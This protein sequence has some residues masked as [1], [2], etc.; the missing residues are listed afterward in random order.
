M[1]F[2]CLPVGVNHFSLDERCNLIC[3]IMKLFM[4]F[5]GQFPDLSLL[6]P[7]QNESD[8]EIKLQ[9]SLHSK[10]VKLLQSIQEVESNLLS[11]KSES[12]FYFLIM[13]GGVP[14][15]PKRA[16]LIDIND[17]YPK[18]IN[19][20]KTDIV[21]F[22]EFFESLVQVPFFDN[23]FKCST[24]TRTYIYICTSKDF[25]SSWFLPRLQFRLPR[26]CPVH[27]LKIVPDYIDS[28]NPKELHKI[29]YESPSELRWFA[30]PTVFFGVKPK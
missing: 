12:I 9:D 23:V 26:T 17:F 3:R 7:P 16:F 18:T 30:S 11:S 2:C 28:H 21:S 6:N 29:L 25:S 24:P 27:V 20:N 1:D 14:S 10:E 19:V 15:S 22:R 5:T 4:Y 13:I 8:S